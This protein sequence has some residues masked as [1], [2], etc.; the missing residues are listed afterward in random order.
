RGPGIR[1]L[2]LTTNG[3]RLAELA[4]P[5]AKAGLRR[6]NISLDT[7][8][9]VKF[10]TIARRHELGEVLDGIRAARA[11]G[12]RPIKINMVVLG[13]LNDEEAPEFA[14]MTLEQNLDVRFIEYMPLEEAK[15]CAMGSGNFTF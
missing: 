6:I 9:P 1:D 2:A 3:T 14:A 5:L 15:G 11:A 7:M 12:L 13:G 8:D 10:K 4:E